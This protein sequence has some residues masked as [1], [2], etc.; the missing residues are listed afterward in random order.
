MKWGYI[1]DKFVSSKK[2]WTSEDTSRIFSKLIMEGKFSAALKFLDAES[3]S[4][5]LKLTDKVI[6]ELKIK[7]PNSAPIRDNSLLFGPIELILKMFFFYFVDEQT[8]MKAALNTKGSV[9]N[10]LRTLQ[11]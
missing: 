9:W 11:T 7:H 2:A 3:S 10:E 5:V 6:E 1:Q 8:V 4:G